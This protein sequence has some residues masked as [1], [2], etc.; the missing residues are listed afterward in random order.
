[1]SKTDKFLLIDYDPYGF[2]YS[3]AD[4]SDNYDFYDLAAYETYDRL[5]IPYPMGLTADI[6]DKSKTHFNLSSVVNI[7]LAASMA[8][9]KM[10][11][12]AMSEDFKT[13]IE[14]VLRV[15]RLKVRISFD[16]GLNWVLGEFKTQIKKSN[17]T[18]YHDSH[19]KKVEIVFHTQLTRA[20]FY[21]VFAESVPD[22]ATPYN[23]LTDVDG[24]ALLN[25]DGEFILQD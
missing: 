19:I 3:I 7:Q 22:V 20:L 9:L 5:V 14:K 13:E 17:L 8:V 11:W 4:P 10:T 25:E 16:G 1:M 15:S 12:D 21:R 2:I 24:V 23:A 18:G 6:K